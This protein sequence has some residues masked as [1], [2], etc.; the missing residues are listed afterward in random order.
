MQ[1]D[2]PQSNGP[3]FAPV[4]RK[5]SIIA[6]PL[7]QTRASLQPLL[8]SAVAIALIDSWMPSGMR[9]SASPAR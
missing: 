1:A 6:S 2:F 7:A 4:W 9:S 5:P 3:V 8:R